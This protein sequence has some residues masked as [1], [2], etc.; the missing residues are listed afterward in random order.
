MEREKVIAIRAGIFL[1]IALIGFGVAIFVLGTKRGYFTDK[2]TLKT[3][4]LNA[5]G[6]MEGAPVRLAGVSAGQ[7]KKIIFPED[8]SSKL[9]EVE[10]EISRRFHKR[11]RRDSS[12]TIKWLS[13][14]TGD[15]YVEITVGSADKPIVEEG[16][17]INSKE[18]IDYFAAFEGSLDA[19]TSLTRS[20]V[21]LEETRLIE[22]LAGATVSLRGNIETIQKGEGILH[23]LIFDPKGRQMF[24]SL[25]ATTES[26]RGIT[27]QMRE[28]ENVFHTLLYD[29]EFKEGI[30]GLA[31]I[32]RKISQS[33][34][35][36]QGLL[37]SLL[38]DPEKEALLDNLTLVSAN[39]KTITEKTARGEGTLGAI[40]HDPGLYEDL[41][42]LMGGVQ[43]SFLLRRMIQKS[44]Q[45]G[46]EAEE[47]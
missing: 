44:I 10:M 4:F 41:K 22:E 25:L 26:L 14:V 16:G 23:S 13:Y 30:K 33:L 12:C 5:R 42:S 40:L 18:A 47:M 7:V 17:Y 39:L 19:F 31:V 8:P 29:K 35:A 37:H 34:E 46:R 20:L 45:K 9:I 11:I 21:K 36:E 27:Q 3:T 32:S 43:R 1:L 28:G 24:D 2:V 6:L 38:F 15:T